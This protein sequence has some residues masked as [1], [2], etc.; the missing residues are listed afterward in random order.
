MTRSYGSEGKLKCRICKNGIVVP[1]A[2]AV[3][4]PNGIKYE[5]H[6]CNM[7]V[8]YEFVCGVPEKAPFS[9]P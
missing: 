9:L 8:K 5:V 7:M 6:I 3:S 2:P 1:T 4:Y